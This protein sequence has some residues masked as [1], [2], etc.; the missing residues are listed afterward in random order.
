M[1][2][3]LVPFSWW[4][5]SD[6]H[7]KTKFEDPV[8]DWPSARPSAAVSKQTVLILASHF[9]VLFRPLFCYTN[10]KRLTNPS[11]W[12]FFLIESAFVGLQIKEKELNLLFP[13]RKIISFNT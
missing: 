11:S 6:H 7:R 3:P 9:A 4:T 8:Q 13:N 2:G 12:C 1:I 10:S 5:K